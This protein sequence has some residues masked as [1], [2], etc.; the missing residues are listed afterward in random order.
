M[1]IGHN[2]GQWNFGFWVGG[3]VGLSGTFDPGD[4]GCH[5]V[6]GSAGI[7]IVS[8]VT[9]GSFG[10]GGVNAQLSTNGDWSV[11]GSYA[12]GGGGNYGASYGK[13][14]LS[15]GWSGGAGSSTAGGFGGQRYW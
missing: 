2:S 12:L 15:S 1:T 6:G 10:G 7:N 9:L 8:D 4:S 5:A 3:G 14:G 11:G 13:S